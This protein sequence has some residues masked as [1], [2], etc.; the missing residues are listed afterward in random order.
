MKLIQQYFISAPFM[1]K[2]FQTFI[3]KYIGCS[4]GPKNKTKEKRHTLLT[5]KTNEKSELIH[6]N[7]IPRNYIVVSES[8]EQ[9]GKRSN[10][11]NTI[12]GYMIKKKPSLLAARCVKKG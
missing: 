12:H 10:V 4:V 7:Y 3:R 5:I 8:T 1:C 9:K 6:T 11:H 2:S